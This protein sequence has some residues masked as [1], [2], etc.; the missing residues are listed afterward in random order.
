MDKQ[1]GDDE[2]IVN[3]RKRFRM[4][5]RVN[6]VTSEFGFYVGFVHSAIEENDYRLPVGLDEKR[7]MGLHIENGR[8]VFNEEEQHLL[9]DNTA[10]AGRRSLCPARNGASNSTSKT[11]RSLCSCVST[12]SGYSLR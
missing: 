12:I 2:E 3:L 7:S 6:R 1:K 9:D 4:Q 8:C 5:F 11:K 10:Y